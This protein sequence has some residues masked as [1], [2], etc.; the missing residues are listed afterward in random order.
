MPR[1]LKKVQAVID[2][3]GWAVQAV[4]GDATTPL[5][6]YTVGLTARTLPELVLSGLDYKLS[7]SALNQAARKLTSGQAL[8]LDVPYDEYFNFP[9]I[10]KKRIGEGLSVARRMYGRERIRAVQMYYPDPNGVFPW[11]PGC[12]EMTVRCQPM[13]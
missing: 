5:L 13:H 3:H 4:M 1:Y 10:F 9:V 8:E 12:D 7:V 2:E 11:E 6:A